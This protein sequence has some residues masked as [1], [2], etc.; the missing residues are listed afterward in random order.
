MVGFIPDLVGFKTSYILYDIKLNP[1]DVLLRNSF[2]VD[3]VTGFRHT[4]IEKI[5]KGI[6]KGNLDQPICKYQPDFE[7]MIVGKMSTEDVTADYIKLAQYQGSPKSWYVWYILFICLA[8]FLLGK[9]AQK[10][11]SRK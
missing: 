7:N 9:I 6:L 11:K 5:K 4:A 2:G 3:Q 8:G 10:L 1:K